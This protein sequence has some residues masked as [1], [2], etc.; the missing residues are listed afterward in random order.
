MD[1]KITEAQEIGIIISVFLN[2]LNQ[3]KTSDEA[4]VKAI[5][6]VLGV[7][8][9]DIVAKKI[10]NPQNILTKLGLMDKKDMGSA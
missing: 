4:Q 5:C 1:K 6:G 10:S 2:F 7:K 3:Q 8:L 9:G